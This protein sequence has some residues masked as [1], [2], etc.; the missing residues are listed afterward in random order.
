MVGAG[1]TILRAST[2]ALIALFARLTGRNYDVVR[3]LL[4]AGFFMVLWNP[5]ILVFDISFQLSFLATIGLIFMSP[6][7]QEK[8]KFLPERFGL[9]D[10]AASTIG[11]QLFVLPFILY[12]MGNLSLVAPITNI[13]VLPFIPVTMLLGFLATSLS[14][15]SH[16]IAFPFSFL[17]HVLLSFEIFIIELFSKLPF[18][19]LELKYFPLVLVIIFYAFVS[20]KLWK[21]YQK[22]NLTA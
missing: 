8:F 16:V 13:L 7:F 5:M 22:K 19:S 17:V 14:F 21:F 4:F 12:K 15:I 20:Y 3:A 9:R 18:S 10:I 11:V 6:V 2:M 1:S